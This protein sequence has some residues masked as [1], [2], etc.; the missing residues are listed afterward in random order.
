MPI[1][2]HKFYPQNLYKLHLNSF[3]N[4]VEGNRAGK[5]KLAVP[6]YFPINKRCYIFVESCQ[7]QVRNGTH[8]P[9]TEFIGIN[10]NLVSPNTYTNQWENPTGI[11]CD[12]CIEQNS[13]ESSQ[14][15][16]KYDDNH[17]VPLYLGYL[18]NEIELF[19]S[20]TDRGDNTPVDMSNMTFVLVLCVQF[21]ED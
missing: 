7:V 20:R 13:G 10:S 2:E 5:F 19:I 17:T 21:I 11:L 4:I 18:P 14:Q 12:V 8:H 1:E 16:Y 9:N 6:K 15:K 3:T